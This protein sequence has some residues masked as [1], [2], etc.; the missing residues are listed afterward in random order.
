MGTLFA[1]QSMPHEKRAPFGYLEHSSNSKFNRVESRRGDPVSSAGSATIENFSDSSS[2][3]SWRPTASQSS[4]QTTPDSVSSY[5]H[6]GQSDTASLGI[7][8][9]PVQ[10]VDV[11][12]WRAGVEKENQSY[13]SVLPPS[14]R[15][16][17]RRTGSGCRGTDPR[18]ISPP[19]TLVRQPERRHCFVSSLVIFAA[20][21][22]AAIWPL[23]A[24]VLHDTTYAHNVLPLQDFITETLRRSKTSYSTLQ[25]AMYYLVLLKAHLPKCDFTQDQS[26]VP[27]DRRAMQCGRRMFLS[28]LMLA[29]KFLQDRNYSTRA[30]GKITGLPTSEINTNE[31]KFL[32]AVNW[33]LHVSK[34]RFERWSHTVIALSSP[35]KTGMSLIPQPSLVETLGWSA[36]LDRLTPDCLDDFLQFRDPS[37]LP[38]SCYQPD[39][40]GMLTPPSSPP[41]STT[42]DQ[43]DSSAMVETKYVR[44]NNETANESSSAYPVPP[45]APHQQNLPTPRGTPSLSQCSSS[46]SRTHR[47]PPRCRDSSSA[48]AML[49]L[50]ARPA[51][52]TLC[53]PPSQKPSQRPDH[54]I[55][56]PTSRR[57]S[58]SS[59]TSSLSSPESVRSDVFGFSG[60]SRSSS[61]SSVASSMLAPFHGSCTADSL[62]RDAP[63]T[64]YPQRCSNPPKIDCS[65]TLRPEEYSAADALLRFHE[66]REN[67]V[68][69]AQ[70]GNRQD[71]LM[72]TEL[73]KPSMPSKHQLVQSTSSMDKKKKKRTHS[74]TNISDLLNVTE[75][76][77]Q[78]LIR[79]NLMGSSDEAPGI[80][81]LEGGS[82]DTARRQCKRNR[83]TKEQSS[84]VDITRIL[85][86]ENKENRPL[87][88]KYRQ[89]GLKTE[90]LW[91]GM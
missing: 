12:S 62:S 47:G 43:E 19:S 48:M 55:L 74:K 5:G 75:D 17:A 37:A 32:E 82:G 36:V 89:L 53:P 63:P 46:S 20:G 86:K 42:S 65:S 29:S 76:D 49:K 83:S 15:Q 91:P 71:K 26:C 85:L 27:A 79:K 13:G 66:L 9:D 33:K 2:Q 18:H 10:S 60:R 52:R 67:E 73:P 58:I 35:P 54:S 70:A 68:S 28:A 88:S 90:N 7:L 81:I 24:P 16:N 21:L 78:S 61:I 34:E 45:P 44:L 50:C 51:N 41:D 59:S 80:V 38:N 22:I 56:T 1:Q 39:L 3:L 30:W 11:P 14:Q 31:I 87:S 57:S 23:S 4:A 25:V 6:P 69:D 72:D 8:E 77:L 84:A 64:S 40:N